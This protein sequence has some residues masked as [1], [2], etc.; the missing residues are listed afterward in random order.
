[1]ELLFLLLEHTEGLAGE[2]RAHHLLR[3]EDVA[4]LVAGEAVE[5]G[6]V[7]VEFGARRSVAKSCREIILFRRG[8]C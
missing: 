8:S 4:E 7:G 3:V 2:V 6:E 5:T 1:V